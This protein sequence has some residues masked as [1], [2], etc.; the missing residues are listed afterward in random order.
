M[1]V[2]TPM[3]NARSDATNRSHAPT[4]RYDACVMMWRKFAVNDTDT[5]TVVTCAI[6]KEPTRGGKVGIVLCSAVRR[7]AATSGSAPM[8]TMPMP[9]KDHDQTSESR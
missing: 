6:V 2:K 9:Q 4:C 8:K 5:R 7:P 1:D 3:K